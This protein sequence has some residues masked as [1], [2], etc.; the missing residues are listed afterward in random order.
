M[1]HYAGGKVSY[2]GCPACAY[3]K[4]V[5]TLPCG[6]AYENELV[7]MSQDWELP[8]PGF[9]VVSPQR[10]VEE[11]CELKALEREA[12]WEMVNRTMVIL[13]CNGICQHFNIIMEE[14]SGIH[15]HVWIMPRYPWMIEK[16]GNPTKNIAKVF[17]YA[18]ENL[19]TKENFKEIDRITKIVRDNLK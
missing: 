1:I 4:H 19:R 11:L 10:H 13:K 8:I 3:A 14:K 7:T 17:S 2:D 6:M 9:M 5:F 18:K 12:V 16:F 15:F